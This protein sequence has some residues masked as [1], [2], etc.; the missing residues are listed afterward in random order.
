M[1]KALEGIKVLDASRIMTGPYCTMML[2]DLGAEVIKVENPGSGD[3]TRQWGPPFFAGESAYYLSINR[4]KK[5]LTL[6]LKHPKG[7]EAF[8]KLVQWADV[9]IEN[10]RPGTMDKL[11]FGYKA[12]SELNPRLVYATVSGFG[13][14]GPLRDKPGY[15]I[16]AQAMGG[17]MG[18][19]GTADGTPVKVGVSVADIG[20]G[21]FITI[22]ILGALMA[23]QH[24]GRGQYVETSL[25]EAQLAWHTY[26]SVGYLNAGIV[27]RRL[28]TA[29][30]S[31][32]PYQAVRAQDDYFIIAV[33]TDAQYAK[34]C[35]VIGLPELAARYPT[36]K[37][38]VDGRVEL[39]AA[40]EARFAT[41]SAAH[42]VAMIEA[43][44]VPTGPI[45]TMDKVYN[46]PQVLAREMVTEVQ[47]PTI[48]SF[49]M[50]GSPFK[51]SDT[52][53]RIESHPPLLGEHT[54]EV[55]RSLGFDEAEI[56]DM[57]ATA[58]I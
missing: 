48:G 44:G 30:P 35:E 42:W 20:S 50:T 57:R 16:L 15:D 25:L 3:E 2:A 38:R 39:L 24:T 56:A 6:N 55:L 5:S 37:D 36:N 31:V 1:A 33:G 34:M 27:P 53:V 29:H 47:H 23:R 45:Y 19:T 13:T 14:T 26:L 28:G 10:F 51:L 46:D 49:K 58:A 40:L 21:M 41:Q 17:T 12:M 11:G 54:D 9:L 32:V 22:A 7:R 4:N 18:V 8:L 52:P 43:A